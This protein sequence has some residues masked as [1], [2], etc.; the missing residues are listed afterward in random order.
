MR[1]KFCRTKLV[2]IFFSFTMF[3]YMSDLPQAGIF[4]EVATSDYRQSP[5]WICNKSH[6]IDAFNYFFITWWNFDILSLKLLYSEPSLCPILSNLHWMI[7]NCFF[8]MFVLACQQYLQLNKSFLIVICMK[9]FCYVSQ[10][11]G[12]PGTQ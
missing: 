9:Y 7:P 4:G 8:E 10:C 2:I 6:W 3:H 12:S 11:N 5:R 1:I